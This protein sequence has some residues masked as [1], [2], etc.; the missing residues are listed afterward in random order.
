MGLITTSGPDHFEG[1]LIQAREVATDRIVGSFW[2][3]ATP[4][5]MAQGLTCL[6]TGN[7]SLTQNLPGEEIYF[8]E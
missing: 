1:F 7:D 8:K 2:P 6:Q 5:G 3:E 4:G